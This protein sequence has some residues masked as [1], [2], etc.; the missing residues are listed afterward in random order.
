MRSRTV[1]R[2][3]KLLKSLT[4]SLVWTN[5]SPPCCSVSRRPSREM[6]EIS[7]KEKR[8]VGWG[9]GIQKGGIEKDLGRE[10]GWRDE[11][12]GGEI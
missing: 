10:R 12:D 11:R 3:L 8:G 6:L 7:N 5:G 9:G 2:L 4:P 1:R